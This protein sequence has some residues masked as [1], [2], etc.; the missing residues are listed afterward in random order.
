MVKGI[1]IKITPQYA[2]VL[3]EDNQYSKIVLK[4]GLG[5]GQKIYFFPE[6]LYDDSEKQVI[7]PRYNFW[8]KALSLPLVAACLIFFFVFFGGNTAYYAVVTV[9]INPSIELK[10]NKEKE[11]I[12]VEALNREGEEISG[13][14]LLGMK[15]QE[16]IASIVQKAEEYNYLEDND[17]V[18]LAATINSNDQELE[19]EFTQSF[20]EDLG[21]ASL[22]EKYSYLF[23]PAEQGDYTMAKDNYLSLGKYEI[24]VMAK[25]KVRPEAVKNMK[26]KE[27]LENIDIKT[28]LEQNEQKHIW[29]TDR[30]N[31]DTHNS[32][33]N[34]K[35]EKDDKNKR[36]KD[37]SDIEK[38]GNN[39]GEGDK[40]K[41]NKPDNKGKDNTTDKDKGENKDRKNRRE[42]DGKDDR[43]IKR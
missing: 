16:A 31:K 42:M 8:R 33:S 9:D 17:T 24:M 36:K 25:D 10:I 19:K 27:L 18:L 41:N 23:L 7:L 11:V 1:I 5:V 30:G 14:Y 37:K 2:L 38:R 21:D 40:K 43:L 4:D 29:L 26:V 6:D 3:S 12:D 32:R 39:K 28:K 20:A 13:R 15:I 34:Q 35:E 22:P